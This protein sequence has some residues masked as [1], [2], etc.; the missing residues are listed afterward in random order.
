MTFYFECLFPI[1]F[2]TYLIQTILYTFL[3]YYILNSEIHSDYHHK[4]LL[5]LTNSY[6]NSKICGLYL[7]CKGFVLARVCYMITRN[8]IFL[9]VSTVFNADIS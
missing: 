9:L 1:L 6:I 3:I 7:P 2:W 5:I 4:S 8:G